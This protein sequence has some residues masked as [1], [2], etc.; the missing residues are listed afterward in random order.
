MT[1]LKATITNLFLFA[2]YYVIFFFLAFSLGLASSEDFITE[3]WVLYIIHCIVHIGTFSVIYRHQLKERMSISWSYVLIL[4][5][6]G[7]FGVLFGL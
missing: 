1:L 7:V 3:Q 2:I 6:W 4:L 5:L